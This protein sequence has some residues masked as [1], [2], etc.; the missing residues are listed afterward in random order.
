MHRGEAIHS[1]VSFA[2][3]SSAYGITGPSALH[4]PATPHHTASSS[5][6]TPRSDLSAAAEPEKRTAPFSST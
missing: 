2:R 3:A 1:I 6:S 4:G 5:S